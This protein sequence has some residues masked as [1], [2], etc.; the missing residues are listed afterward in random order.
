M[1]QSVFAMKSN[2]G[3]ITTVLGYYKIVVRW[4][5]KYGVWTESN[6]DLK[7]ALDMYWLV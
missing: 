7:I 6:G 4:V 3:L 1:T 5:M 2:D